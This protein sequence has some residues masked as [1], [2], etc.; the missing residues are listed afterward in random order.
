[1]KRVALIAV[2]AILGAAGVAEAQE[3][4]PSGSD[5]AASLA[6]PVER[7][8]LPIRNADRP[9]T[10]PQGTL[11]LDQGL[12]LRLS[13]GLIL[14]APNQLTAGLTDWLEIGLAWPITRDPSFLATARI[15]HGHVVDLGL[16]VAVMVPAITTGDTDLAVSMPLVFRV[17]GHVVRIEAAFVADFLLTQTVHHLLRV[18]LALVFSPSDRHM[19]GLVGAIALSDSRF[20]HGEAGIFYGHTFAATPLRPIGEGRIGFTYLRGPTDNGFVFSVSLT[21]FA[22]VLPIP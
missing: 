6:P 16:R 22:T 15:A 4:A 17:P 2:L 5:R 18:P 21:F 20:W 1:M 11:R 3:V 14:S 12:A 19:V 9:L 13:S 7:H 10:L 8:I